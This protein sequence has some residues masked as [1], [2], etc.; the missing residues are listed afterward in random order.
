MF[1]LAGLYFSLIPTVPSHDRYERNVAVAGAVG[2][3][4]ALIASLPSP[5]T[6]MPF[7]N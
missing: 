1:S 7:S 4:L 6:L 3:E 2:A 5:A